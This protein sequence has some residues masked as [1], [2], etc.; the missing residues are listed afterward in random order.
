[1]TASARIRILVVDDHAVVRSGIRFFLLAFDDLELIGE[2][3]TGA[4][5]LALSE[6]L[7]P[8][9]VLMDLVM[10]GLSGIEAIRALKER[11]PQVR[12]IAL[13]SFK[14]EELVQGALQAGALS[15]IIKDASEE[16]L[17]EAIRLAYHGYATI[18]PAAT[19]ALVQAATHSPQPGH[20]L[21]RRELEVLALLVKG[22]SN[23]AIA[24]RLGISL[25]T[26]RYHVS[27]ILSKLG[28]ANRA[29]A[30]A[31]ALQHRLAPDPPSDR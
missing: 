6:A 26:A 13:T 4:E 29:Q 30:A 11:R 20:D 18:A 31:L 19:A 15:Y 7:N 23:T 28:A 2:A 27:N 10:P 8:D 14:D 17:V 22:L 12:V 24:G 21:T 3:E 5:A 1:M 25:A 9:V 16:E